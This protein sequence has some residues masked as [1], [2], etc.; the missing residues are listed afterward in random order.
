[1]LKTWPP[2]YSEVFAERDQRIEKIKKEKFGVIGAKAYYPDNPHEFIED[3]GITYDPRNAGVNS[4]TLMPFIMFQR[5]RELVDFILACLEGQSPGLIEKSRDMGATWICCVLSVWLWLFKP[6]VAIGWG[7]RKETLVDKLGD[8]DSI[9]EKI[10]MIIDYTPRWLWPKGFNPKV[11]CSYM[12]IINPENGSTITGEAGD[13]I[14]RG[15]RKSIY[16][17]DEFAHIE[18]VDKVQ[19]ALEDNTNVQIDIS[20]VCGTNSLF[21]RKRQA[22]KLWKANQAIESGFVNVFILDWR[23]HPLKTQEWYDKRRAKAVR[24]GLLGNFAQEVDRDASAS[25]EGILIPAKWV[26]AAIDAHVNLGFKAE[27]ITY[28]GQDVADEGGDKN[29]FVARKGSVII[30]AEDWAEGDTTETANRAVEKSKTFN[31][32][33]L[34]YDCIGVGAGIK[35]E[36]NRLKKAGAIPKDLFIVPW[37]A[38]SSPENPDE[39]IYGDPEDEEDGAYEDDTRQITNRDFFASLKSQAYWH[40]RG[41][42]YKTYCAVTKGIE[43]DSAE[44]ISIPSELE[45]RDQ[46]EMELSQ[47]TYS[48]SNGKIV[49]DKKPKGAK[50]PNLG[51]AT[52]IAFFPVENDYVKP[53]I[54]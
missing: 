17:V 54:W 48:H 7:S 4:L 42:F 50:S 11:H 27:G 3:W 44:L 52:V 23:D 32:S 21:F 12:K 22:G 40:L 13:N 10:R 1:M 31:V 26:K 2:K 43:Y 46:L 28:A 6:G 15:G 35:G 9:F 30:N 38:S 34:Q 33:E 41:R 19:A 51:D 37:N 8:P 5:Q 25:V 45:N 36:T 53:E 20:S 18:R 16:F 47:P 14:G 29:A 49:V 39:S 24:E